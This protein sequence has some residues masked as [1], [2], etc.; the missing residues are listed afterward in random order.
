MQVTL[1]QA[2]ISA[3]I[4]EDVAARAVAAV[5]EHIDMTVGDAIKPLQAEMSA[6]RTTV[7]AKL[8]TMEAK[9]EAG[10]KGMQTSI[11]GL[12]WFLILQ[13]TALVGIASYVQLVK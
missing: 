4:A 12:K 2:L 11:D 3:N 9:L 6:L 8:G 13:G 7:D 10:L 5:E 1:F